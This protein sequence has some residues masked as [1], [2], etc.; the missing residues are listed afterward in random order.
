[1]ET[2]KVSGSRVLIT[3]GT[4]FIGT[5][6]A[7]QLLAGGAER[8]VLLDNK[9]R[10]AGRYASLTDS[11]K[12]E[13]I[14]A[15][16]LDRTA[17]L[18]AMEGSDYILHLAAIAG[19]DSVALRPTETM[20]VN[21]LGTR[22]LMDV[23]KDLRP[24][25][26]IC[27]STSEVYGPYVYRGDERTMT[28]Q[29]PV[30]VFRWAYSVSK[31]AAEH[32]AHSYGQDYDLDVVTIRPFNVYGPR[33]VGEGAIRKFTLAAIRGDVLNIN[34]DGTQIRSWCFIDDMAAGTIRA[35]FTPAAKGRAFNI[36]NPRATVTTVGLAER[37]VELSGSSSPIVHRDA[38][39][40][41]VEIRVPSIDD[42]RSILG[43]EPTVGLDD[44]LRRTI[45]WFR[46]HAGA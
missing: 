20:E 3:G 11:P 42:A 1:M 9:R 12:V 25:R 8:I 43:F 46:A 39:S 40:A 17:I 19:V 21:L 24:K 4:G 28:T 23:A 37:I 7:E 13:L 36:G 35:L 10:N 41:D 22:I 26:V 5:A 33:Q 18:R 38:L 6:I 2:P 15:D 45:E 27:F 14:E 44:G 16:I 32:W 34:G 29:G 30:G 31:L